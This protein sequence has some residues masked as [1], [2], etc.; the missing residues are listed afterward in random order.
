MRSL[1]AVLP[2]PDGRLPE[3]LRAGI[4][5]PTESEVAGWSALP[6]GTEELDGQGARP[7]DANAAEEFHLRTTAEPSVSVNGVE[8]GSPHLQKTVLP[9]EA[10][11]NVSIRLA[12]G[13]STAEIAPVFERLLRDAAPA[14][15]AL[16][17]ELW[18]TGE[19]AYVDP[20]SAVVQLGARRVRARARHAA[21][22]YAERRVDP[23]RR[24]ARRARRARHRHGVQP[25]DGADALAER[26]LPRVRARRR[27]RDDRRAAAETRVLLAEAA[28]T[29]QRGAVRKPSRGGARGRGARAIPPL[30]RDRHAGVRGGHQVPVVRQ[31]ARPV[32]APR[33]RAPRD[34]P[35]RRRAH[36][37]R[38]RV[39]DPSRD[40]RGSAPTVGLIAHVDTSPD[41][42]G[43]GVAPV[44]HH[45][46]AGGPIR[47]PGDPSQVLDPQRAAAP[48]G[49]R[50]S[51]HRHERRHDA[52]RRGRQGRASPRSSPPSPISHGTPRRARPCAS[53]SRSTKRSAGAR[54]T[55]TSTGS[56]RTS[57]TRSTAPD[58]AR[59]RSRRSPPTS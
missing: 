3:P 42:P 15:T 1:A 33:R 4:I 26:E 53:G 46:Y 14:G 38:L 6:T 29:E 59:S 22:P 47:L 32:A 5:P 52:A 17:V 20:E 40:R 49:A 54:I 9:V 19:P 58:S 11:A 34:R 31:A 7:A 51:R 2:G 43:T 25:A 12:P 24:D 44:L 36:R 30:R 50:R 27:A 55:S 35:R 57:P 18:S 41:A 39:R 37:A 10:I 16:D 56:A 23:R 45:A 8:S 28:R 48:G 21:G 13:Q